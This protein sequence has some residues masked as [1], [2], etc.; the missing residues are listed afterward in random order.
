M[1]DHT[2]KVVAI[3]QGA[4]GADALGA[5]VFVGL[6][7]FARHQPREDPRGFGT[8]DLER[9]IGGLPV[10]EQNRVLNVAL[11]FHDDGRRR[12]APVEQLIGLVARR[13]QDRVCFHPGVFQDV[14]GLVLDE[15]TS[16]SDRAIALVA[17]L[18]QAV[19]GLFA[20]RGELGGIDG[21]LTLAPIFS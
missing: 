10:G 15:I 11:G 16:R 13:A 3:G 4:I 7:A 8:L 2:K 21:P 1:R 5:Q 17:F 18:A 6:F 20:L 12:I 9:V 19:V 14:V